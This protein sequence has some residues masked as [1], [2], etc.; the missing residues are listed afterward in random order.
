MNFTN[1]INNN[2]LST[3]IMRIQIQYR[4]AFIQQQWP[5][6]ITYTSGFFFCRCNNQF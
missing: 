1:P 2:I 6:L 3:I 4:N 5:N